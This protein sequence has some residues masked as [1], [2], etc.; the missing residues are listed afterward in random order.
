MFHSYPSDLCTLH[1][2][3]DHGS[4]S[5]LTAQNVTFHI[6]NQQF[7]TFLIFAF[8]TFK[9]ALRHCWEPWVVQ[10]THYYALSVCVDATHLSLLVLLAFLFFLNKKLNLTRCFSC[11]A[12]DRIFS[13][14]IVQTLPKASKMSLSPHISPN[15]YP[16]LT[17]CLLCRR[18]HK[19]QW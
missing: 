19:V 7:S 2:H 13:L 4:S 8:Y 14:Q 16:G 11:S 17:T 5:T 3:R 12:R 15:Y 10:A 1:G 6:G 9:R 18:W